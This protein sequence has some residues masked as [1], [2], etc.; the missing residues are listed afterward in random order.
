MLAINIAVSDVKK[1]MI[2][3]LNE[4]DFEVACSVLIGHPA[5]AR[6]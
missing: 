5:K 3:L 4:W 1:T 6:F 2:L